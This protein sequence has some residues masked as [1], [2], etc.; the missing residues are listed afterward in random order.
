MEEAVLHLT[1]H[2]TQ[3]RKRQYISLDREEYPEPTHNSISRKFKSKIQ[4]LHHPFPSLQ[5]KP[6]PSS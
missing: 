3:V 4:I 6:K 5:M 1:T 2:S